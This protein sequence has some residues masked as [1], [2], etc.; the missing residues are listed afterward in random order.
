MLDENIPLAERKNE[1]QTMRT[2]V[3]ANTNIV[4]AIINTIAIEK[5][6]ED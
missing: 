5:M 4:S 2:A 1:I 3:A 6:S